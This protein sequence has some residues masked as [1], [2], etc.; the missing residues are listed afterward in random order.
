[1]KEKAAKRTLDSPPKPRYGKA[2]RPEKRSENVIITQ[3]PFR[4][5]FFGGGT[6]FPEFFQRYGGAV[7]ST[8]FDKYVYT[9]VRHLPPFFD[10]RTVVSYR[11]Q[12]YVK[13][14]ADIQHPLVRNAMQY[15]DMRDM[16]I[17][18]DADL[19]ARSGLGSSSAFAVGLLSAFYATKGKYANKERLAKDAILVERELC[20][21][22]GGWQDQIACA[23]GGFN[24]ITFS[25]DGFNVS[26]IIISKEREKSLNSCLMLFFTGISRYSSEL[27]AET[28]KAVETKVSDLLEMRRLVED[29]QRIL[30]SKENMNEFGLLMDYSWKLKRSLTD[31]I[32]N[33]Q[34]DG[35]YEDAIRAGALGG[36]L[37]GA[38]GG[39]FLLL[40][41]P[42]DY[43]ANVRKAL[44]NLVYVPFEFE[45]GGVQIIYYQAEDYVLSKEEPE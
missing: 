39:G 17:S 3:T 40:F 43:Q 8:T 23:Y 20:K 1:V 26:P 2:L 10:W 7:L 13:R 12:E 9:H 29:A 31:R 37:L 21:E 4:I 44:S 14:T 24:K 5:S 42:P 18:Y 34:L 38:G 15:L 27:S 16:S 19:P 45:K 11:K 41:V 25:A 32:S 22:S 36:K 35:I 33:T 6:D 30:E 28:K